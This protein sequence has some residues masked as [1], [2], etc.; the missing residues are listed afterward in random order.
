M[1]L[2]IYEYLLSGYKKTTDT[3]FVYKTESIDHSSDQ[4]CGVINTSKFNVD[5]KI[6]RSCDPIKGKLNYVNNNE[7][8]EF[9]NNLNDD[10]NFKLK[11][12]SRDDL[13]TFTSIYGAKQSTRVRISNEELYKIPSMKILYNF[14]DVNKIILDTLYCILAD[15][16]TSDYTHVSENTLIKVLTPTIKDK[17]IIFGDF[18]GSFAT[19]VRHLIR[20]RK[21]DVI[22]NNC[23][24]LNNYHLIFLGDLVDRGVYGYEIVMLIY[25]LKLENPNNVH[26]NRGNHEEIIVNRTYG[27][28][29]DIFKQFNCSGN[30]NYNPDDD[31]F[32]TKE[33]IQS[34]EIF[35]KINGLFEYQ[36]SALLIQNPNNNKYIYLAHGGLPLSIPTDIYNNNLPVKLHS[37]LIENLQSNINKN[38]EISN[39]E[40]EISVNEMNVIRWAD[41]SNK[42]ITSFTKSMNPH[43]H[44]PMLGLDIINS[45]IENNIELIIR[46]H[47]DS[48][49]NTKIL[50]KNTK[51]NHSDYTYHY[52]INDIPRRI[53]KNNKFDYSHIININENNIFINDQKND[54]VLPVITL[55][56]NTDFGRDLI[57][58]SFS[59]LCFTNRYD[60]KGTPNKQF[61]GYHRQYL[62]YLNKCNNYLK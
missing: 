12:I 24:L 18:H 7:E 8:I 36:H 33:A 30:V 43:T 17:F 35:K 39:K 41:F 55:S 6:I 9:Y 14:A 26:I 1:N 15:W 32:F 22:D 13:I 53:I 40:V 20:L 10:T 44:G 38:I 2:E 49:I 4:E 60:D 50:L 58:D 28:R 3:N 34:S 48:E 23:K 57:R 61:G 25:L 16:T 46:G 42:P 56:T 59:I 45:A 54:T 27:F 51:N 11:T 31:E 29:N 52:N 5:P 37:L 21:M 19:F 47:E 62:K